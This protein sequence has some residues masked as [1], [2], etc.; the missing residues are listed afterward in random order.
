M[1]RE[2]IKRLTDPRLQQLLQDTDPTSW[3]MRTQGNDIVAHHEALLTWRQIHEATFS[4]E[5][6]QRIKN[7]SAKQQSLERREIT[8]RTVNVRN[9]Q[10]KDFILSK[11]REGY[12]K[13]TE[14]RQREL[15]EKR[16]QVDLIN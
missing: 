7:L 4:D 5:E 11:E 12:Q 10:Y 8:L 9:K 13:R 6:R 1:L 16:N 15:N 14:N 2:R 3:N